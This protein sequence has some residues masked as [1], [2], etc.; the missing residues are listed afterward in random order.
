MCKLHSQIKQRYPDNKIINFNN[1]I[2]QCKSYKQQLK[3]LGK[4][5]A[6]NNVFI[7]I[8]RACNIKFNKFVLDLYN[9]SDH[10]IDASLANKFCYLII[11]GEKTA[12]LNTNQDEIQ[13]TLKHLFYDDPHECGLCCNE[14]ISD[15]DVFTCYHCKASMCVT[16]AQ[17]L[18]DTTSFFCP[19]CATHL[20]FPEISKPYDCEDELDFALKKLMAIC[21]PDGQLN[22]TDIAIGEL[23][24]NITHML[25]ELGARRN[26]YVDL[27]Y[28]I[29]HNGGIQ[30]EHVHICKR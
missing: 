4:L 8:E 5:R 16:C 18:F 14:F 1:K 29:H 7:T 24:K 28:A 9:D 17:H 21:V 11:R 22:N 15:D 27:D 12:L 26:H 23:S 19:W 10:D 20:F 13:S 3:L 6:D 30:T 25:F 2:S